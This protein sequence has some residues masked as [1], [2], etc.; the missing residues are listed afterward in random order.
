MLGNSLQLLRQPRPL[1]TPQH[2]WRRNPPPPP[3]LYQPFPAPVDRR[4]E[5]PSQ[6]WRL[7]SCSRWRRTARGPR[8][9]P[10]I[11]CVLGRASA[12]RK[13][14]TFFCLF[15]F[16]KSS[17]VMA[18]KLHIFTNNGLHWL[19]QKK[20]D[21]Q[22]VNCLLRY[23]VKSIKET[24]FWA[25]RLMVYYMLDNGVIIYSCVQYPV[26]IL[27]VTITEQKTSK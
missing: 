1:Q 20:S 19:K 24:K 21:K 3:S 13:S 2:H 22:A 4:L 5:R 9:L 8:R 12:P 27:V 23:F 15:L 6:P 26:V 7:F 18:L 11:S 14:V 10:P 17:F 25:F 16:R